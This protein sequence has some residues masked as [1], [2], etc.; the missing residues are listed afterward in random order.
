MTQF[1]SSLYSS[2][3]FGLSINHIHNGSRKG[4][5]SLSFVQLIQLSVPR[6]NYIPIQLRIPH[7]ATYRSTLPTILTID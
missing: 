3:D 6:L 7:T 4:K 1:P 2:L 5:G